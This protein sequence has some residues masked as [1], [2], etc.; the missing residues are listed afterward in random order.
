MVKQKNKN[1][2]MNKDN[3]LINSR[4]NVINQNKKKGEISKREKKD[5]LNIIK[6]KKINEKKIKKKKIENNVKY[7]FNIEDEKK[8]NLNCKI[9][10]NNYTQLKIFTFKTAKLLIIS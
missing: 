9:D 8:G 3:G 4:K 7:K 1:I 6:I 2:K 5:I 10:I